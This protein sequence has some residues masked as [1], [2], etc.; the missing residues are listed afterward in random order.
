MNDR[1]YI[2]PEKPKGWAQECIL[3]Q[4]LKFRSYGAADGQ[5]RTRAINPLLLVLNLAY[6]SPNNHCD[7]VCT[8]RSVSYTAYI[9]RVVPCSVQLRWTSAMRVCVLFV[10][11][12]S[13]I[14]LNPSAS[15]ITDHSQSAKNMNLYFESSSM[16]K[17][18]AIESRYLFHRTGWVKTRRACTWRN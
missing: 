5:V 7:F 14:V 12:I 18:P 1:I 15:A 11:S 4:S 17:T 8:S 2:L 6:F 3:R 10:S 13:G 16:W 9:A